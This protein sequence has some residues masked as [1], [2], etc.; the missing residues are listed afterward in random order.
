MTNILNPIFLPTHTGPDAVKYIVNHAELATVVCS[1]AAFPKLAAAASSCQS[2]RRI[3]LM[4]SA[5]T[6]ARSLLPNHIELYD[7]KDLIERGAQIPR[8]PTPPAADDIFCIM[9][10]SGTTG[11]P[12]VR[13]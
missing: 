2:L 6:N 9:Y 10:T 4:D 11:D 12:K 7:F 3:V 1:G 13:T 5:P 8:A